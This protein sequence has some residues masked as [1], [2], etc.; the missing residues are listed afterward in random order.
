MS[1]YDYTSKAISKRLAQ[2][3]TAKFVNVTENIYKFKVRCITQST[4]HC[5]C[6]ESCTSIT[7]G[8]A[9]DTWECNDDICH[10]GK[11][12]GNRKLQEL[13]EK[14]IHVKNTL[15]HGFGAFASIKI[16]S[17]TTITEYIGEVY[18]CKD[19]FIMGNIY[20]AKLGDYFIDATIKGND[21]RYINHSCEANSEF[22]VVCVNGYNRL[23]II[24]VKD[25]EPMEEVTISYGNAKSKC[26]R[27][28]NCGMRNCTGFY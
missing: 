11:L 12:C 21:A 27:K 2:L 7:C 1:S 10:M 13:S 28:C 22:K 16:I 17:G 24:A 14:L 19:I 20:C 5:S 4:E 26:E 6:T 23:A 3:N 18:L 15:V 8:N 9:I 25:I